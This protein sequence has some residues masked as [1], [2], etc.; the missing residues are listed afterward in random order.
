M[1]TVV[2]GTI[3]QQEQELERYAVLTEPVGRDL[4]ALVDLVAQACDVSGAAINIITRNQQHQIVATAGIEPS[5]CSRS[6][7]MCAA[8]MAEV[9]NVVVPD[10][11]QD[12]RFRTNPFVTGDIGHVRFYASSPLITPDDVHLG[13]LC[14]FDEASRTLTPAQEVSLRTVAGQVMD[15][16]EL[17]LRTRELERANHHLALFAGQVSHDLRSPLTAILAN[18]ELLE[19]EPVVVTHDDLGAVVRAVSE[20]GRRMNRMIEEMLDFAVRGGQLSLVETP[21]E[22]VFTLALADLEPVVRRGGATITVESLPTVAAD[23]DM[24]YSVVL[25]LLTNALKFTREGVPAQVVVSAERRPDAWRVVVA[26]NGRG[27]EPSRRTSIF[28]LFDRGE[29]PGGHGI[30]LATTR[31]L[32]HAHGGRVGV[33]D[34]PTGGAAVWFELPT[35]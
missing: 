19:T 23:A 24:L 11:T 16:L 31:R 18:A 15:V 13:R 21:L 17:R 5:V 10:A 27:I 30:G 22:H 8:V 33:D 34:S 2:G 7:S 35:R 32:V 6:D 29:D 1:S 4:Q 3:E 26:D 28:D 9:G 20:A 25:N 14:L 12:E